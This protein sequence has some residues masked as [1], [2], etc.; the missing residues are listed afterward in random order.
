MSAFASLPGKNLPSA[1]LA[2][3]S[4][5]RL[6]FWLTWRYGFDQS[7]EG[8]YCYGLTGAGQLEGTIGRPLVWLL[9]GTT[10]FLERD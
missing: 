3:V 5:T 1:L 9:S 10:A 8:Y 2:A 7:D 6:W 4:V